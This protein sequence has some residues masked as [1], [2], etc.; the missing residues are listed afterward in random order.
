VGGATD[1]NRVGIRQPLPRGSIGG[2]C[3][4]RGSNGTPNAAA[5]RAARHPITGAAAPCTAAQ[6]S[7]GVPCHRRVSI[8]NAAQSHSHGA[9]RARVHGAP[10]ASTVG[11]AIGARS[12]ICHSASTTGACISIGTV[13]RASARAGPASTVAEPR[14]NDL[15]SSASTARDATD[16]N[17][18]DGHQ[19]VPRGTLGGSLLLRRSS[20]ALAGAAS[21][22]RGTRLPAPPSRHPAVGRAQPTPAAASCCSG[23]SGDSMAKTNPLR[24]VGACG[25]GS[26][27]LS[28]GQPRSVA[29]PRVA[30]SSIGPVDARAVTSQDGRVRAARADLTTLITAM[31]AR[32][33]GGQAP[34]APRAGTPRPPPGCDRTPTPLPVAGGVR[35]VGRSWMDTE[36]HGP[37]AAVIH[38]RIN[39]R[40]VSRQV[41][42][43]GVVHWDGDAVVEERVVVPITVDSVATAQVDRHPNCSS[44]DA[45]LG[46]A[47]PAAA[48]R[49]LPAAEPRPTHEVDKRRQPIGSAARLAASARCTAARPTAGVGRR[50]GAPRSRV[51]PA[52]PPIDQTSTTATSV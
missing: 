37:P 35:L 40:A 20:C 52:D 27:S 51:D 30:A 6:P 8:S 26:R 25:C 43:I 12:G 18:F 1:Y 41:I 13:E 36:D 5:R 17:R 4:L 47:A 11:Q 15:P 3:I 19:P 23:L 45:G 24:A 44:A 28:Q 33:W 29:P 39:A 9:P 14:Y 2:P 22:R 50:I 48:D 21:E 46:I 10:P 38:T 32:A 34:L 16:I 49:L 7:V 42:A 31:I